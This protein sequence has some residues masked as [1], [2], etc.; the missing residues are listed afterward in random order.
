MHQE[1]AY[2]FLPYDESKVRDRIVEYIED[3][4]QYCALVADRGGRIVGMLGGYLTEYL[5]CD[6][7]TA[8]D[9]LV[10]VEPAARGSS[11]GVRL[12]REFRKWAAARGARE[13]CLGIST[14]VDR[15]RIGSLYERL[16]FACVGG[17]YKQRLA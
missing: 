8:C 5:F 17:V 7:T 10:F 12:V 4:D 9:E 14:G 3:R 2:A 16:G 6:E 15:E 13:I 1:G 11:A